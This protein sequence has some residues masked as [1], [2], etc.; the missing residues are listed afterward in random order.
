[1]RC[2]VCNGKTAVKESVHRADGSIRRRRECTECGRRFSSL[3][4]PAH[5]DWL[6]EYPEP[7]LQ[8]GA[9]EAHRRKVIFAEVRRAN[10]RE[11]Q[12]AYERQLEVSKELLALLQ[13][14]AEREVTKL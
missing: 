4:Y 9:L 2:T 11:L 6:P 14:R 12:D 5:S 13:E 3:E 10:E 7:H 8:E 1:M